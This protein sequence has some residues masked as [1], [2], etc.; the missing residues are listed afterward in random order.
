MI[1]QPDPLTDLCCFIREMTCEEQ[2]VSRLDF[3][4]E[5]H[6]ESRIDAKSNC[7]VS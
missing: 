3:P 1:D 4:R 6:E 7:H 5:P 2:H